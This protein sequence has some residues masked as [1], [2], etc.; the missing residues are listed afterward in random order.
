MKFS[1]KFNKQSAFLLIIEE[2]PSTKGKIH[3][4]DPELVL[5]V[6]VGSLDNRFAM[7]LL[8]SL[9][10]T[11]NQKQY[12]TGTKLIEDYNNLNQNSRLVKAS[13]SYVRA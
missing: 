8:N 1:K 9:K 6:M 11:N 12:I 7:Y 2:A 5:T 3:Y 4:N 13:D 10:E